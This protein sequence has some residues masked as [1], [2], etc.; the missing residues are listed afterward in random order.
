[1]A[2]TRRYVVVDERDNVATVVETLKK[3]EVKQRLKG[4]V[5]HTGFRRLL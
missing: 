1:M 2:G 5:A 4:P 3:G